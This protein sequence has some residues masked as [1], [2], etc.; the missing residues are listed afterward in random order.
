MI[1]RRTYKWY[2]STDLV[3]HIYTRTPW[4]YLICTSTWYIQ[5]ARRKCN[6]IGN[7]FFL[8]VTFMKSPSVAYWFCFVVWLLNNELLLNKPQIHLRTNSVRATE[9]PR[10]PE[11]RSKHRVFFITSRSSWGIKRHFISFRFKCTD[12]SANL[13]I[14]NLILV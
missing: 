10:V 8:K 1:G 12:V 13:K 7:A 6:N 9:Q 5:A 11:P 14:I 3:L 2:A 4:Y